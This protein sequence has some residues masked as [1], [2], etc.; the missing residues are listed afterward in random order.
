ML[1]I[2]G[3][4]SQL[5]LVLW[6]L[7]SCT[8]QKNNS[9]YND[10]VFVLEKKYEDIEHPGSKGNLRGRNVFCRCLISLHK[11]EENKILLINPTT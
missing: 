2:Q 3:I 11:L 10:C 8:R 7:Y 4:A 5:S 1:N 6:S 9:V